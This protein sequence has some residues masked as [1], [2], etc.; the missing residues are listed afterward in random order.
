MTSSTTYPKPDLSRLADR[1]RFRESIGGWAAAAV[2]GVGA[3]VAV[4]PSVTPGTRSAT[5]YDLYSLLRTTERLLGLSLLGHAAD[6][7]T[8]GMRGAFRL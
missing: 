4:A 8:A 7:R 6:D 3:T 2:I 5:R 1:R